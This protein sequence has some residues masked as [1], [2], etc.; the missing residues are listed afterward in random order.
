MRIVEKTCE[1]KEKMAS[2]AKESTLKRRT[3]IVGDVPTVLRLQRR[4]TVSA[5][6]DDV[7]KRSKAQL[8]VDDVTARRTIQRAITQLVDCDAGVSAVALA[9]GVVANSPELVYK[10]D[11]KATPRLQ[12]RVSS[13]TKS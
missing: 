12:A 11:K 9:T 13:L 2:I 5:D 7:I 1:T 6:N 4:A 10:E 3:T 8:R